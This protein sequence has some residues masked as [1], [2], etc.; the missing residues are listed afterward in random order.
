MTALSELRG[1][2][3]RRTGHF[4]TDDALNDLINEALRALS[5]EAR[6]PWLDATATLTWPDDEAGV[7]VTT[8]TMPWTWQ[9]IKS[10]VANGRD[11]YLAR[12]QR[13]LET[14]DGV[15]GGDWTFGFA[16]HGRTITMAPAPAAGVAVRILGTRNE[17]PLV[18]D[19]DE[20]F[21]PDDYTDPVVH[22]ACALAFDRHNDPGR[23][24]SHMAEYERW[25]KRMKRSVRDQAS[26]PRVPRVRPGGGL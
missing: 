24:S 19:V 3:D 9:V 18:N 22:Y 6:W 25:V 26:G 15:S 12:A 14:S 7:S 21:L 2:V 23:R 16:V 1:Q 5:L 4:L 10:V 11:E 20:P 13:D 8:T 17:G